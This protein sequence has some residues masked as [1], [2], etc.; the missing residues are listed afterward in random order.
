MG[1][2]KRNLWISYTKSQGESF[3]ELISS[4]KENKS[5]L[6]TLKEE[7]ANEQTK[8]HNVVYKFNTFFL[9]FKLFY[10]FQ[11]RHSIFLIYTIL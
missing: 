10:N 5:K 9:G 2:F 3:Q 4:Y 8:W 11:S 1:L 6:D 7:M